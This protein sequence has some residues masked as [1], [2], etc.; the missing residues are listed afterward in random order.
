MTDSPRLARM[1]AIYQEWH[2]SRGGSVDAVLAL[3]DENAQLISSAMGREGMEFT[4]PCKCM[5]DIRRYFSGLGADW[6]MQHYTVD[7]LAETE[8]A[9]FAHGSTAWKHRATGQIF[10]VLKADVWI[11]RGDKVV[12][13]IEHY[14]SSPII[15][16]L[17]AHAGQGAGAA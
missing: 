17:Q 5:D 13:F 4:E 9:V 8:D 3:F 11:F 16:A 1:R 6:E 2:D 14:D 12:K 10:D 15:E 7:R